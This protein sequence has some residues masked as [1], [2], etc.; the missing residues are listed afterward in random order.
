MYENVWTPHLDHPRWRELE[1]ICH[2]IQSLKEMAE[3]LREEIDEDLE[4]EVSK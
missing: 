4:M 3:R 2:K 1:R